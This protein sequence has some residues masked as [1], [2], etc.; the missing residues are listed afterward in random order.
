MPPLITRE[1]MKLFS[2]VLSF[3]SLDWEKPSLLFDTSLHT[4]VNRVRTCQI[5]SS[6]VSCHFDLRSFVCLMLWWSKTNVPS[7]KLVIVGSVSL[8]LL[9]I[10]MNFF[11]SHASSQRMTI[12]V[13]C[14][15][16]SSNC[17]TLRSQEYMFGFYIPISF[18]EQSLSVSLS[19]IIPTASAH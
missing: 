14:N 17:Y 11:I 12:S 16:V 8:S 3:A 4:I 15:S 2:I 10:N 6:S 9:F 7:E 5:N 13:K 19:S 1:L 18:D